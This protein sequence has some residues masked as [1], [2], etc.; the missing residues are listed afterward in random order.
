[1]KTHALFIPISLLLILTSTPNHAYGLSWAFEANVTSSGDFSGNTIRGFFDSATS[2][3]DINPH[4]TTAHYRDVI[5]NFSVEILSGSNVVYSGSQD[6]QGN[7]SIMLRDD[8]VNIDDFEIKV[9]FTGPS[10]SGKDAE[11]FSLELNDWTMTANPGLSL[12]T[13]ILDYTAYE[14]AAIELE[15]GQYVFGDDPAEEEYP[16]VIRGNITSLTAPVPEPTSMALF[17]FGLAGCALA[18]RR[19]RS[20]S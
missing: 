18:G 9:D 11:E 3:T 14:D 20:F 7:N 4:P 1:M 15:F 12:P 6:L 17:A 13:G 16:V 5:S 8:H 10:V 19:S 2:G